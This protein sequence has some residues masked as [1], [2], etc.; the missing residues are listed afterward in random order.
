MS[1]LKSTWFTMV[2]VQMW[3]KCFRLKDSY[4]LRLSFSLI[5]IVF[6]IS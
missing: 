5:I 4:H 2:L 6:D 3:I 1:I